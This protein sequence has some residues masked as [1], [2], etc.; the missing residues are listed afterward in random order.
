MKAAELKLELIRFVLKEE[1]IG[2]LEGLKILIEYNRS[3][4]DW[5]DEISEHEKQMIAEGEADIVAGR[6]VPYEQV[7][8]EINEILQKKD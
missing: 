5:W 2:F 7:R 1:D 6:V 4:G 3:K 8:A